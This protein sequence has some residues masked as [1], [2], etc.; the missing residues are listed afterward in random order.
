MVEIKNKVKA[1]RKQG[2][3]QCKICDAFFKE[4][5]TLKRHITSVHEGKKPFECEICSKRFSVRNEIEKHTSSVH[6][7][8]KP[9]KCEICDYRI[10][11]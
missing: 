9:F 3:F 6:E 7:E 2:S 10:S 1:V 8:K 5:G 11:V 4:M